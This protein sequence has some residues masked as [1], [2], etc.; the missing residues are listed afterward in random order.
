[1]ID[2]ILKS[3]NKNTQVITTDNGDEKVVKRTAMISTLEAL[4]IALETLEFTK[5]TRSLKS[6][7]RVAE[8][9][10][11]KIKQIFKKDEL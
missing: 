11:D 10:L 5:N 9:R 2:D 3:I 6:A 1:M 7:N 4:R 8:N